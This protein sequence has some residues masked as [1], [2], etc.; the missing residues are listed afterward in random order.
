MLL[1]SA[2]ILAY[3][4]TAAAA[5]SF[6][7]PTRFE[8]LDYNPS[9]S[10]SAVVVCNGTQARFT[11]LTAALIRMQYFNSSVNVTS[12][13]ATLAFVNRKLDVPEFT[14][15]QDGSG[16]TITTSELTLT[17]T[18]GPFGAETL[19]A[20]SNNAS[21]AFQSWNGGMTSAT[22]PGSL[23][24]TIRTLDGTAN[25]TLN[26]TENGKEHC[27]WGVLSRSG[28]AVVDDS[29]N[30]ILDSDYDWEFNGAGSLYPRQDAMDWYLFAHGHDYRRALMDFGLVSG[31]PALPP[32][33][34]LGIWFTR[35]FDY[36]NVDVRDI[37]EAY[38]SRDIP[39][40]VL[41]SPRACCFDRAPQNQP[42]DRYLQLTVFRLAIGWGLRRYW[43]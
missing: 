25:V 11:V 1:L 22:D 3:F 27:T 2:G 18:G 37:V 26:C 24:G 12:D 15:S 39:L 5:S 13:P 9:P 32:R 36:A 31:R 23:L 21:S 16:C 14:S 7:G 4:A 30:A 42:D 34:A 8:V 28:W 6:G 20:V 43:T 33:A 40:D 29:D 17:Y 38:S 41:V 19:K 10:T 35:W